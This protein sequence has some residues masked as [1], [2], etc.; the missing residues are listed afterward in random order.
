M[1]DLIAPL[2]EKEKGF[3]ETIVQKVSGTV[4]PF[5][6][7]KGSEVLKPVLD[8]LFQP[9]SDAFVYAVQGFHSHMT[10]K[11]KSKALKQGDYNSTLNYVDWEMVSLDSY[12]FYVAFQHQAVVLTSLN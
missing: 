7:E 11:I 9:V 10:E 2:V 1:K 5:L 3:K 6:S 8:V 4:D 12:N